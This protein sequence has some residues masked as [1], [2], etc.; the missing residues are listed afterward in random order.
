MW[1]RHS[2]MHFMLWKGLRE[3]GLEPYVQDPEQRLV[4]INTIKVRSRR[5]GLAP[6]A[7]C[8]G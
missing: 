1:Q 4:T 6:W 7:A 5:C 3:M 2:D 8:E